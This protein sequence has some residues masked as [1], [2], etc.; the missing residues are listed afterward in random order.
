[1]IRIQANP[2]RRMRLFAGTPIALTACL[3][4]GASIA[5]PG[6]LDTSFGTGGVALV[7]QNQGSMDN[8]SA[9]VQQPDGKLLVAGRIRLN[10]HSDLDMLVMRL[11]STGEL[12]ASFGGGD[13]IV[14]I[15]FSGALDSARGVSVL[16]DGKIIVGGASFVPGSSGNFAAARLDENGVLDATFGNGG[17]VVV[18]AGVSVNATQM[19]VQSDARIVLAGETN[20]D[21]SAFIFT[22]LDGGGELDPTFGGDGIVQVPFATPVREMRALI[23]KAGGVLIAAGSVIVGETP[24]VD[25]NVVVVQLASD[26]ALDTGFATDGIAEIDYR[27]STIVTGPIR[28]LYLPTASS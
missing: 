24:D 1:M 15:D 2:N 3:W 19:L 27:V 4:A 13:G 6:D 28:R 22:R 25:D 9:V 26:G 23:E 18:D 12:D 16:P 8:V 14:T 20:E 5:A 10:G 17:M 7:E 21:P 11:T